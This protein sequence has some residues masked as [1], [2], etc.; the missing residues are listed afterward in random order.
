MPAAWACLTR[1]WK[2]DSGE[3]PTPLSTFS[4][5]TVGSGLVLMAWSQMLLA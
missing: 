1:L 5:M 4:S 2:W 3:V